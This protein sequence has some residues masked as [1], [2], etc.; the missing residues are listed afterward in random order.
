MK[1]ALAGAKKSGAKTKSIFVRD[2]RINPCRNC[3]KCA[4]TGVCV[5]K[6]DF[7]GLSREIDRADL[8]VIASPVYFL[9]VPSQ[10]KA[11]VDRFQ[12]YWAR[13]Y[14]LKKPLARDCR[15]A[16]L[17]M[18]AGSDRKDVFICAQRTISA[19]LSVAGY[20]LADQKFFMG[21]D[22]KGS[23]KYVPGLKNQAEKAGCILVLNRC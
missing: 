6:D 13:K 19:F 5:Q 17:L 16:L 1:W 10:A 11:L 12:S 15:P 14:I 23:V 22:E 4:E 2:F 21:I 8:L 9:G 3:G 7:P 20:R 18:V